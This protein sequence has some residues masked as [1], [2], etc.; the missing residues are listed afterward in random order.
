M[1]KT[2]KLDTEKPCK[3]EKYTCDH[4]W[5]EHPVNSN[6]EFCVECDAIC[7]R[8]ERGKIWYYSY[9]VKVEWEGE[10]VLECK[11]GSTRTGGKEH[12]LCA[13]R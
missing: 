10:I 5:L 13:R 3:L 11:G 12:P 8:D 9:P 7:A 1:G 4:D 6:V 2:C